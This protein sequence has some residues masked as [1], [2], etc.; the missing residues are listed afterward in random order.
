M[1]TSAGLVS[2]AWPEQALRANIHA[3]ISLAL[4]RIFTEWYP[5]KGYNFD[6]TNSTSYDQYYVHGRDIF[7]PMD[8][9]TDEIFNTYARKEGTIE[10]YYTEY[11]D[12]KSVSCP[13]MKQWGTKDLADQGYNALQILQYYYGDD[14]E[15]VRTD[16]IAD[17]QESY[18][19]SPLRLGSTSQAVRVIQR[20]LNRIA[21]DYPFFGRTDVDG[22]FGESTE[23]VVKKFQVQFSLTADG[24]VGRATW[25]KISYIYASVKDLAELT[26]EGERPDGSLVAGVYPGTALRQGSRGDAVQQVQFWLA[27]LAPYVSG[28]TAPAVD[29]IFGAATTAA[30]RA[31]QRHYGLT[32]DGVVGRDTWNRLYA[33]YTSLEAD[34]APPEADGSRP[35]T[36]PGTALRQ[37]SRG[38]AVRRVQFWL[39]IV[40]SA[41]TA[42]PAPAVDGIFGSATTA[43]VQAF[44]RAYGLTADGVVGRSTWNKLYEV[45]TDIINGLLEPGQRPGT[46]PGSPLRVG[47]RGRAVKEVQYYLCL[48]SAYYPQIPQIAWDGVYGSATAAAVRAFQQLFGLTVDGV[49]G[50]ATWEAIYTRFS[51]LRTA[52]G[53]VLRLW[54]FQYPG[55]PLE[56]GMDGSMVQFMQF[57]LAYV[58]WFYDAVTPISALDGVYG[59]ETENAVRAF[60]REFGLPVTGAVDQATWDAVALTYL[61]LAADIAGGGAD[62]TWPG[63]AMTLGSAGK[64]VLALQQQMNRVASLYCAA[65]FVPESGIFDQATLDAVAQFQQ[66]LGLPVTGLVDR[67][68][69]DAIFDFSA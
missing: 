46:Y 10:P 30:V 31:F 34:T 65:W 33:E 53:P 9:I 63:Y 61:S 4:N 19:G 23:A 47:S 45:Y 8:R 37:G 58:A 60:Q 66:G 41:N 49:V 55:Y 27:E 44:Q 24:V 14:L 39:R 57:M 11:C 7:E 12:G 62:G 16:N 5:S 64:A 59:S 28:L 20:Q 68:T 51:T 21:Q 38:D 26:S 15:L 17:V 32:V 1:H 35:G 42:V 13:G 25:Y 67:P 36:Y 52:S 2:S 50:P 29:G 18:P 43:S 48:L 3:Q 54:V 6:I 56:P 69:W 40:A 22:V